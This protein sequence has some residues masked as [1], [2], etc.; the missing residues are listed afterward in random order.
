[1]AITAEQRAE[2]TAY[3]G[4][5]DCAAILGLSRWS[6]PLKVWAEK[7][8][9]LPI[10]DKSDLLHIEVGNELEDLVCRLFT[11]RT[12][13]QVRRVNETLVH[14]QYDFIRANIDRRVVGEDE[15]LEAKTAS[16]WKAKEW[17]GEDIP[18]E[19]ILQCLHQLACIP[20]MK[21]AKLAV[22]IGGNQQFVIKTVE[23]DDKLI[24]D[25]VKR[26]VQFWR[27]FVEKKIM[28]IQ[29]TKSDGETLY[30][31]FPSGLDGDPVELGD[32][33]DKIVDLRAAALA[34]M[35]VLKGN[36]EQFDAQ[37]K[38]MLKDKAVGVTDKYRITWKDQQRAGYE[39]KPAKMRV[40]R[41]TEIK[42]KEE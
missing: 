3:I 25:I 32:E 29:I 22:L 28:P 26:E 4:S 6:S 11:K 30:A 38:A 7:T 1:M 36:L 16:G 17:A 39:V 5:S 37:I 10:E 18:Q 14:P 2:R 9:Q 35:K 42:S 20:K 27:E 21:R 12:G 31:L 33:A 15:V 23:R 40:L 19:Y 24:A 34:D 41:V 13:K 8:G